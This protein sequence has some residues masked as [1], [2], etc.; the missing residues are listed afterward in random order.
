[1][2]ARQAYAAPPPLPFRVSKLLLLEGQTPLHFFEALLLQLG[3]SPQIE[4]RSF[5]GVG[6]LRDSLT[7]L[8]NT[9]GFHLIQSLG[10]VRDAERD[11]KAALAA[12]NGGVAAAGVNQHGLKKISVFL[13]PDNARP[14]MIET[15]LVDS[16]RADPIYACIEE[17]FDCT[18]K[19]GAPL[20]A[21]EIAAKSLAQAYLATR[22]EV[23][24]F[25][26]IAAYRGYWPW[27]SP[28]FDGIK[29]F[30]QAL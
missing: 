26:G 8:A 21:G 22:P 23:Q 20:P 1:M 29:Q 9:P 12:V 27:D 30:L 15:L 25:P 10:I 24:M 28:A 13:L 2:I 3:L 4:V 11:A 18:A 19:F 5:G 6:D 16:L 17:F 14:G 7:A